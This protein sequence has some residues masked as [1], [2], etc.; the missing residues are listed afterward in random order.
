MSVNRRGI[1]HFLHSITTRALTWDLPIYYGLH[2]NR[3]MNDSKEELPQFWDF[4]LLALTL[5]KSVQLGRSRRFTNSKRH[6]K[7][8]LIQQIQNFAKFV[9]G[10]L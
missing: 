4:S 9:D 2:L 8:N 6:H 10:A 7:L 3:K 5:W 1:Q